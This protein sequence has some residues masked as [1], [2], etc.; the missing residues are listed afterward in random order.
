MQVLLR[1]EC[2]C[3]QNP[4]SSQLQHLQHPDINNVINRSYV[5][6]L[7]NDIVLRRNSLILPNTLLG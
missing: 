4:R 5:L 6:D 2:K 7:R 1:Y 3:V